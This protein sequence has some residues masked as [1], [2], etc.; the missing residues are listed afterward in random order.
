MQGLVVAAVH[1]GALRADC[2]FGGCGWPRGRR[3]VGGEVRSRD[4]LCRKSTVGKVEKTREENS[5][6][7][8][9]TL[10]QVG[11]ATNA[12]APHDLFKCTKMLHML[13]QYTQVTN[14]SAK[15][16][17]SPPI[18]FSASHGGNHP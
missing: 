16:A 18:P 11:L 2:Y 6:I 4:T 5:E 1:A 14:L 3:A 10:Q 7:E 9:K 8:P 13:Q 12:L 17:S 15:S